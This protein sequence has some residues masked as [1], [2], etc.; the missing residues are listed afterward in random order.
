MAPLVSRVTLTLPVVNRARSLVFLISGEDKAEAVR[1]AFAEPPDPAAPAS[2]VA[3]EHG[4]YEAV[5]DAAAASL[6]GGPR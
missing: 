2:L 5:L 3:P 6:L 1:R 4:S